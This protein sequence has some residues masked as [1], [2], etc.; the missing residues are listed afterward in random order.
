M[1]F[2]G[3]LSLNN[4]AAGETVKFVSSS[5]VNGPSGLAVGASLTAVTTT[6][7][8]RANESSPSFTRT[9]I[10]RVVT[11]GSSDVLE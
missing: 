5:N 10:E 3:S 9:T 8:K 6:C 7:A 2:S 4:K 11:S 1:S